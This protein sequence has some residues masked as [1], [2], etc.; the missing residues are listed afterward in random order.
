MNDFV[1]DCVPADTQGHICRK[2][3]LKQY[4]LWPFASLNPI[5]SFSYSLTHIPVLVNVLKGLGVVDGKDTEEA[6]PCPHILI[7]HGTV[8][9]L[10][11]S[12]QDVQQARLSINHYL[13]SVR[14]LWVKRKKTEVCQIC[15]GA[16]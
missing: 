9:L 13:L 10:T 15:E 12:V 7:P 16:I 8:L 5:P 11:C 14:V 6:L 3:S 2:I 1:N 4:D